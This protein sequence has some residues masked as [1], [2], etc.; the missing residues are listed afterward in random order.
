MQ[1]RSARAI[2]VENAASPWSSRAPLVV[3]ADSG[4]DRLLRFGQLPEAVIGDM[5]SISDRARMQIPPER[6]YLVAEQV[7]T[8]F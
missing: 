4:A 5:D 8:D 2:S 6:Q 3:A 7:T 1:R